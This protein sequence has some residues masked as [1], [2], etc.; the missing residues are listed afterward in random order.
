M[1]LNSRITSF[2]V[3]T[4]GLLL[5]VVLITSTWK[6]IVR[7]QQTIAV[8]G[9]AKTNIVSDMGVLRGNITFV[10]NTT[11]DGVEKIKPQ[12]QQLLHFLQQ[13]GIPQNTIE[14]L[15]MNQYANYETN[16][17]GYQTGNIISYTV[18]Q[19]FQFTSNNVQL[20]KKIS[21]EMSQL[22]SEGVNVQMDMPEYFYSKLADIKVSIQSLAAKD[23]QQRAQA[24]AEATGQTLG[25]MRSAKMGVIQITPKNSNTISDYGM[26]D[27]SSI[28]KEITAVVHTSFE[29]D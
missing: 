11:K 23:A 24:M 14:L 26:N 5:A 29:I 12:M 1:N 28:E 18:S 27:V 17:Q 22:I 6:S 15:P 9:S 10:G 16:A 2:S 13:K 20:I 7:S 4:I 3:L 19:R 21:L 25:A 8:T